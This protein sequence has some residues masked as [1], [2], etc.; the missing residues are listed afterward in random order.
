MA[1]QTGTNQNENSE[2]TKIE[3]ISGVA[4]AT[5]LTDVTPKEEETTFTSA[6]NLFNSPID[7]PTKKTSSPMREGEAAARRAVNGIDNTVGH[8]INNATPVASEAMGFLDSMAA[9][10]PRDTRISRPIDQ[11]V[12]FEKYKD[13]LTS[14]SFYFDGDSNLDKARAENQSNWAQAR[15]ATFRTL[16]NVVPEAIKQT[17]NAFDFEDWSKADAET[18]NW[19]SDAMTSAQES[20]KDV[21]PIYRENPGQALDV[22]DFAYWM[23]I[24]DSI[25]TS[26][27]GFALS[28]YALGGGV[29]VLSKGVNGIAK[30]GA[31]VADSVKNTRSFRTAL[32]AIEARGT[33]E[34][35]R[36]LTL[37]YL[38][39]R[40]ESLGIAA[41]TYATVYEREYNKAIVEGK[42]NEEAKTT[43]KRFAAEGAAGSMKFNALNMIL[44]TTSSN[45][46]LKSA[47]VSSLIKKEGI[48][49]AIGEVGKEGL[50]EYVN[51]LGQLYGEG[52]NTEAPLTFKAAMQRLG[53]AEGLESPILGFIG[54]AGQPALT[55]AGKYIQTTDNSS[56]VRNFNQYLLDNPITATNKE[57]TLQKAVAYAQT[58][59]DKDA[60][61]GFFTNTANAGGQRTSTAQQL[62]SLYVAQ[63]VALSDYEKADKAS[64]MNDVVNM[65]I[66]S[67]FSVNLMNELSS[68][69]T[70][71]PEQK[72]ILLERALLSHQAYK[73][74]SVGT[75]SELKDV[76]RTYSTM[77]A[78]EATDRGLLTDEV[79]GTPEHYKT[80]AKRALQTLDA[81]EANYNVS[82]GFVNS[83][84]V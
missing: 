29:N 23:E 17:A 80:K 50:E 60:K 55:K 1:L 31:L 10:A 26:I 58:Q 83:S 34:A 30:I 70:I 49:T 78:K 16:L 48:G 54:G 9:H 77:E 43:A 63:Q 6:G 73:A 74:M 51:D 5:D 2:P 12:D 61:I 24:G 25:V 39:N 40:S 27:G 75:M 36:G 57:E 7:P 81:Y 8:D 32:G 47:K 13:Y 59:S 69:P 20:V 38:M 76:Y 33:G 72:D 42:S 22:G 28:G 71:S 62:E 35:V 66:S 4:G 79:E 37:N 68:D 56:Y 52:L 44:N 19:V 64:N 46:F 21:L 82:K 11:S 65:S 18:G 14:N 3:E 84:E 53:T 41:E 45:L 67:E 15:N